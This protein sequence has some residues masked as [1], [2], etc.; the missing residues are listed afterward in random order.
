[1]DIYATIGGFLVGNTIIRYTQKNKSSVCLY[2]YEY[3]GA[4]F[5]SFYSAASSLSHYLLHQIIPLFSTAYQVAATYGP[6]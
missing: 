2:W 1:M 6:Y 4:C 5:I 3:S